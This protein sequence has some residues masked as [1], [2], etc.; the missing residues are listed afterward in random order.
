MSARIVVSDLLKLPEQRL[1]L[2]GFQF[3]SLYEDISP[4]HGLSAIVHENVLRLRQEM[5][6]DGR[7]SLHGHSVVLDSARYRVDAQTPRG[8]IHS[9]SA[10]DFLRAKRPLVVYWSAPIQQVRPDASTTL[11]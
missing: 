7:V 1:E 9:L 3:K 5:R 10:D 6:A 8:R 4:R 2:Y 11:I